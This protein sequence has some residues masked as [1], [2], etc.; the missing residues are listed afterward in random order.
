MKQDA[1]KPSLRR[2]YE[3]IEF[4][5]MWEGTVGRKLLQQKFEISPQQATIDLTSYLD[6][7]PKNMSYDPRQRTYVAGSSFRPKFLKGEASEYLLHL[8]M[9]HHGYRQAEEIWP[10][11]IPSFDAV[12]VAS[13]KADPA[14]LKS[15]LLAIRTGQCVE[16]TYVSLSSEF[17]GPRR[18]FPHA[19][20]SD[21]HRWHMR[22][23]DSDKNRYSDF[24][25]SRI[26]KIAVREDDVAELPEDTS[27]RSFISLCFQP[28]PKLSKRQ[29]ERLQIEYGMEN[30]QLAISVRKAMLFYYLR[31]Y[32]F[33]PLEL[34]GDYMRNKSSFHL[35]LKNLKEVESCLDRRS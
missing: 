20:A 25:L 14:T 18:L 8:E 19:I 29:K 2:R 13:R 9:L 15:V 34:E 30:G 26:E 1:F 28:D 4:Q 7:A 5:L 12:A 35:T 10:A 3:F 33:D 17:E 22:A 11:N 23:F 32:G 24:V 6:M 16:V 31:F 21:G 27:W